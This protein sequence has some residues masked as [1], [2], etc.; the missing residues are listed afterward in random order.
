MSQRFGQRFHW[1]NFFVRYSNLNHHDILQCGIWNCKSGGHLPSNPN[2]LKKCFTTGHSKGRGRNLTRWRALTNYDD[3]YHKLRQFP[4]TPPP[5]KEL[6]CKLRQCAFKTSPNHHN[7]SILIKNS[8][9]VNYASSK[10]QLTTAK[11]PPNERGKPNYELRQFPLETAPIPPNERENPTI[12]Y[13]SSRKLRRS[14]QMRGGKTNYR[15]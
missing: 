6:D 12:N 10:W 11:I 13:A 7:L 14:P 2:H 15:L 5:K 9:T 3:Y 8:P 1:L 4:F